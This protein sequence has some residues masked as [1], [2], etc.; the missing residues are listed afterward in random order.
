MSKTKAK[1]FFC[2]GETAKK[3]MKSLPST[4]KCHSGPLMKI[5]VPLPL[6]GKELSYMPITNGKIIENVLLRQNKLH[7]SQASD[8]PL[9]NNKNNLRTW[10]FWVDR[11]CK[12]N[13][14][15]ESNHQ[16]IC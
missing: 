13:S 9:E 16:R 14:Y 12:T 4:K 10:T 11:A 8:T 5:L 2:T 1:S 7:F 15:W 3:L 6:E